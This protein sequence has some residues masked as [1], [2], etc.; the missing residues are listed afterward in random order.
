MKKSIMGPPVHV[1]LV[2]P[3]ER[4][5]EDVFVKRSPSHAKKAHTHT[6]SNCVGLFFTVP[7][8]TTNKLLC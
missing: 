7:N 3:G 4:E 6:F 1:A 8:R 5:T 2:S